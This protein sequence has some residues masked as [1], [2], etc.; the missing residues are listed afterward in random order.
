MSSRTRQPGHRGY[1]LLVLLLFVALLSIGLM[2][3]VEQIDFQIKRDRE[4]ELIHR[5]VQ[6]ARAIK[7]YYKK[8]GRY[9]TRLEDLESTNNMR[10]LRRRYKDPVTGKDF[11]VLHFNDVQMSFGG[12]APGTPVA[13]IAAQQQAGAIA[14][15]SQGIG[16]G[17]FGSSTFS[18]PASNSSSANAS[19]S[20]SNE[21]GDNSQTDQSATSDNG[22]TP[23]PLGQQMGANGPQVFGG[24][25]IVGVASVSK[26]KTIREFN[27]KNHYN[28]WYFIYDP[29][30]D[31]GQL[32]TGPYN[33]KMLVTATGTNATGQPGTSLPNPMGGALPT[34]PT[35]PPPTSP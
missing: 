14:A 30:Q 11:K 24:G 34:T 35:V 32:L 20:G 25:A 22:A 26:D 18:S 10:F 19:S 2:K 5:G 16:A 4:E 15:R 29:G 1:V 13:D 27:K 3:A 6:Y 9:P 12:A 21:Q 28:E 17:T 23:K 31:K 7:N 33:P 8:F